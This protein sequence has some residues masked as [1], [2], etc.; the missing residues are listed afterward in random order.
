MLRKALQRLLE[1]PSTVRGGARPPF[2]FG[3]VDGRRGKR[4][5]DLH[6]EVRSLRSRLVQIENLLQPK[7]VTAA[8][9]SRRRPELR[10]RELLDCDYWIS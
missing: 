8:E 6:R 5:E 10:I 1:G 4:L 3:P 7:P 2:H 9:D